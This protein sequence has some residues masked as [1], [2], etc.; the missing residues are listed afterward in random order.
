MRHAEAVSAAADISVG[1]SRMGRDQY[2]LTITAK[3]TVR[4]IQDP[5][6]GRGHP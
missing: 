1:K 5:N 6:G 3:S 4:R 2:L